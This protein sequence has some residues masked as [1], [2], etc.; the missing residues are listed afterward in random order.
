[1]RAFVRAFL[2]QNL[3]DDLFVYILC[4]RYPQIKYYISRTNDKKYIQN[5]ASNL[6]FISVDSGL[7]KVLNKLYKLKLKLQKQ[8]YSILREEG[9]LNAL[10]WL[11]KCNILVTGSFF[12]QSKYWDGIIRDIDWYYSKPYI[13]GCNFG[14]FY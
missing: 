14:P 7:G 12:I 6:K 8:K 10:S 9:V 13:L 11:F 1:M 2:A 5:I 4:K 3:G